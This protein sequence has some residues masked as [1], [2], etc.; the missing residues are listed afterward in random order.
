MLLLTDIQKRGMT[1]V[2]TLLLEGIDEDAVDF[3]MTYNEEDQEP[4]V[5]PGAFPNLLA[6]GSSGIAV[7]MATNIP[8]HNAAGLCDAAMHLIKFRNAG[9]EKLV[10]YVEGP[11]F[12]TGGIIVDDRESIVE[13][14]KTGRGGFRVRARWEKEETGRG[15]YQIVVT[16]IP[17]QV[18]KSRLIEKIAELLLNRRL[19]LLGDVRDESAEDIRIVFEPKSRI[20]DPQIL[21]E[22]LFKLTELESRISLNMNVL[23]KGKVPKVLSL[24][25]VLLEWLD[26]RREVLIRR[27]KHRLAQIERRLE[28]FRRPSGC[29][30]QH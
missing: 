18:Q 25:E 7:G 10:E 8:P 14:Y 6:N 9:I 29:L 23:S 15:M 1:Q 28:I 11:D 20:V 17:Y 12:P 30:S 24:K 21:M 3:R 2:A 4:I 16:E 19:P 27:S 26:H 13:A 5:L 22:S